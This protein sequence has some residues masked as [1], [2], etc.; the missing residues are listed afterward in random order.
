MPATAAALQVNAARTAVDGDE[1]FSS[2]IC[3][4]E[5]LARVQRNSQPS[6]LRSR[7]KIQAA[8]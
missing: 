6:S 7:V 5:R 3:E 2:V 4:M 1:D 8:R